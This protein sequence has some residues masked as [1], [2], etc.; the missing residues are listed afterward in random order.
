MTDDDLLDGLTVEQR[1]AVAMFVNC[2]RAYT[3]HLK[4][5]TEAL[6][7]RRNDALVEC[8]EAG[9]PG[10]VVARAAGLTHGRIYQLAD[11]LDLKPW[12]KNGGE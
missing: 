4:G 7:Q 1:R 10:T 9:V 3:E 2:Q 8:R 5:R 11:E 6:A 12:R